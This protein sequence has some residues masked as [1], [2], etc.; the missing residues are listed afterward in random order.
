MYDFNHANILDNFQSS[1]C[2]KKIVKN[3]IT[4]RTN[5]IKYANWQLYK[6]RYYI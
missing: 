3:Q 6:N 1:M 4:S 2:E 5:L